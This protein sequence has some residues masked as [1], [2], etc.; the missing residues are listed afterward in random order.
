MAKTVDVSKLDKFDWWQFKKHSKAKKP[1]F[2]CAIQDPSDKSTYYSAT[3]DDPQ[4]AIDHA[5]D[6]AEGSDDDDVKN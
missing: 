6:Q 5:F 1:V 4:A 2:T 3:N